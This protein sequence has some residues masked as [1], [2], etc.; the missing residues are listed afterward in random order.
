MLK[1]VKNIHVT[2]TI[3]F[4]AYVWLDISKD[5]VKQQFLLKTLTA[6]DSLYAH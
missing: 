2:I 1:C 6:E 3:Y 5:T 4:I